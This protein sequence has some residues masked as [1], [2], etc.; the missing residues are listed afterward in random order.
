MNFAGN[1]VHIGDVDFAALKQRVLQVPEHQ[2]QA[3]ANRQQRYEVHR[4]TQTIH[5]VFDPD[6]RHTHPTRLPLLREF[7]PLIRPALK[8][9]ADH[10]DDSPKGQ[11][12]FDE[13]GMGYFVRANLVRLKSGGNIT[14]HTDNNY[15]LVHSHRVHLPII[16]NPQVEFTVGSEVINMKEGELWEINNRRM[17]SVGNTG[18]EDRVHLIL[19]Y[20]I[21]GE[22]CCCGEK[23]H[24][25]TACNPRACEK[26]DHLE[27]KC[28]CFQ[29]L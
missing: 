18:P 28:E 15:S 16:T 14:A 11:A 3:E 9:A 20:V 23:H 2:W 5:L 25:M 22:K 19:D 27:I 8:M 13:H 24:P 10:F 12:L 6:F 29:A 17:H 7:E 21:P 26:T 4:D 1:F